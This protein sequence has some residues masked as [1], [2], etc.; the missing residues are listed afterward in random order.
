MDVR[1]PVR[2]TER[3]NSQP[4]ANGRRTAAATPRL[5]L[6]NVWGGRTVENRAAASALF[7]GC[8][9]PRAQ[10]LT[11]HFSLLTS[12]RSPSPSPSHYAR[13]RLASGRAATPASP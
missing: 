4:A 9:V 6:V 5:W 12:P 1:A 2:P 8:Q 3:R 13:D 7:W 10:Y 11:S